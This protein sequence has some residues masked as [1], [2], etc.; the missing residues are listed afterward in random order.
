MQVD[1][2]RVEDFA[3]LGA[4]WRALEAG[5]PHRS[6]FQSWSWVGCL[7]AERFPDPV[8]LRAHR[9]GHVVGLA[10]F[11]R[12]AGR[13]CLGESGDAALDA[14]FIEHNAPLC[15]E[16]V[17]TTALLAAAWRVGR[18]RRLVLGGVAPGLLALAG[19]TVWGRQ[20]RAAPYVELAPIRDGGGNY[21]A[22][23]SANSRQQI[24]RSDR[25]YAARGP[26]TLHRAADAAEALQAFDRML[27]WHAA[28]W[29]ARG[30]PGAFG[31]DFMRRFHRDLIARAAPRGE[32]DLLT[33]A[34]GGEPFGALYNLRLGGIVHAYQSGFDMAAAGTAG[35]PGLTCHARAVQRACDAG[36]ARYD[37]M[38]GDSRYKRSLANAELSL[39]WVELVPRHSVLGWAAALRRGLRGGHATASS[40]SGDNRPAEG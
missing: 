15:G 36:D 28:T 30:Q 27:P 20:D 40:N 11:N 16:A 19:G 32:V 29:Q 14:P 21:L 34:A 6:F 33:F 5:L 25:H 39:S 18:V 26:L 38:A 13:L 9:A 17:V 7:A 24:R 22:S 1:I 3:A 23:R 4:E 8:L 35:K 10:L 31:G 2:S 12:R 37:F